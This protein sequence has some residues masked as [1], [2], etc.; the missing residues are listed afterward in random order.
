MENPANV[1]ISPFDKIWRGLAAQTNAWTTIRKLITHTIDLP[2]RLTNAAITPTEDHAGFVQGELLSLIADSNLLAKE[3]NVLLASQQQSVVYPSLVG[4]WAIIEAA[5][6]DLMLA[7]L[8]N[9]R[10]ADAKLSIAGIKTSSN[11]TVASMDWAEDVYR[12]IERKAKGSSNGLVV[13]IHRTC[14]GA[15]GI[16][17]LYPADRSSVIEELNQVRN[18]I[19]HGQGTIDRK[20]A[21][22]SPRLAQYV[23]SPMPSIDPLFAVALTM[24][25]DYTTAWVAA[26]VHSPYLSA[27]LKAGTKNPFSS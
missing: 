21:A 16:E 14:F 13:E 10:N 15:L 17:L 19:L 5:F 26:L 3:A 8:V 22:I 2:S 6:D 11:Q 12:R 1:L 4:A 24:L 27:G 18:C 23:G 9:D 20:A 25:H 7:V